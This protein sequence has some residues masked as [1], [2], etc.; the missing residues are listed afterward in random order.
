[1]KILLVEDDKVLAYVIKSNL[2]VEYQ[3]EQAFDG[4]EALYYARQNVYDAIVLDI[5]IP[6]IEGNEVVKKL[7]KEKIYTPVLILTAKGTIQDKKKSFACGSDDYLVKPFEKEELL[8]RIEAMIRR[9]T[10]EYNIK[11]LKLKELEVDVKKRKVYLQKEEIKLPGK[12]Y[13]ILEYLMTYK[14]TILTKEQIFDKI[15]GF[16]SDTT[17]NVV[18]VYMHSLRKVL[19]QYGY[20]EYLVTVKGGGYMITEGEKHE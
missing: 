15:W 14:E 3:V 11:K 6:E 17:T 10:G 16:M 9:S 20:D 1:M 7:R 19:K 8:M 13:D 18:E 2:E 5:M 4:K 12:Q